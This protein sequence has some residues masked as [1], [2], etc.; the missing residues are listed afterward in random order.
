MKRLSGF[1]LGLSLLAAGHAAAQIP[2]ALL[3]TWRVDRILS[4]PATACWDADRARTLLG[5]T[6][7]YEP[8]K[9][10]WQGGDV[11]LQGILAISRTLNAPRYAHEY[12]VGFDALGIHAPAIREIDLQ[13][14]DADITGSTTEVPG[15]TV[16]LAAPGRIIVSACGVFYEASRLHR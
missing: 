11:P 6:L 16:V 4:A 3:G 1:L 10:I 12:T 14:E 9:M 2:S 5:T 15:D 13:H 8:S 7:T